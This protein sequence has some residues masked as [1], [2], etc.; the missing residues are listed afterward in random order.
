MAATSV[1]QSSP[2]HSCAGR[3][4]EPRIKRWFDHF[5]ADSPRFAHGAGSLANFAMAE[6]SEV[7]P[8]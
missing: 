1:G 7:S 4:A 6:R 8:L 5:R 2:H 3:D